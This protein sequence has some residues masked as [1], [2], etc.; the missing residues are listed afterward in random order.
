VIRYTLT[1]VGLFALMSASI[2]FG[3][4]VGGAHFPE[5][6]RVTADGPELILNGAGE[7]Y[8]L[9]FKIYAIGLYLPERRAT[10][11]E[12]LALKGPK[13][14][15]WVM[16]RDITGTQL[17]DYLAKRV[18]DPAQASEM[19]VLKARMLE[20]DRI[21]DSVGTLATDGTI[22]IDFVPGKGTVIR[23][24]GEVRGDPI[25]GEDFYNALLSIWLSDRAKSPPLRAALLGQSPS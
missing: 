14:L 20:L 22:A 16:R 17:K 23:V 15:L 8:I 19:T 1:A 11:P 13:R 4:D 7:R 2:A 6:A 5:R 9:F 10:M 12:V 25:R 18:N 3:L 24:N 21:I